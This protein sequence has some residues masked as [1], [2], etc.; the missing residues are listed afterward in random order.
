MKTPRGFTF[1][2]I[3]AGI[4][5]ARKDLALV[6]SEKECSAAGCFTVNKAKAAPVRDAESRLPAANVR[7]IVANSGN[8]NALTGPDGE[9]DVQAVHAA[10]A[11]ALGIEPA[12]VLSASTGVI[13]VRLPVA[14]IA[15]ACPTLAQS[16][17]PAVEPAAEAILTTDTRVKLSSRTVTLGGKRCTLAGF[18]KGS[19]MI[20]PELATM[21]AFVTTDAAVTP[22]ALQSALAHACRT[23]FNSLTVDDDMSTNDAVFALANGLAGGPLVGEGHAD[24]P[25]FEKALRA[26]CVDLARAI[27]EDGEGATK[28]LEVTLRGA[29]DDDVAR[30]L[31]KAIAGSS[32]VKAAMFGADPNSRAS[33]SS[34]REPPP[35]PA[36]PVSGRRCGLRRSGSRS[37]SAPAPAKPS[38]GA[39]ICP[40]TT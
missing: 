31:A 39:A 37:R 8:A 36:P 40:T 5:A 21:L 34:T 14:K 18:A 26:V 9:R 7:A 10:L 17:G 22:A 27:A 13:G 16:R 29:P 1:A 24:F 28:L 15:R 11:E 30:D 2:G 6:Y 3:N 20:A 12:G 32:L 35:V 4:K 19:G 23:S 33:R 38:P 25:A